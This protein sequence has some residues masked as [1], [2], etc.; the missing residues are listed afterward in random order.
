M[1]QPPPQ[2]ILP[3]AMQLLAPIQSVSH[4]YDGSESGRGGSSLGATSNAGADDSAD[5]H[6]VDLSIRIGTTGN[7]VGSLGHLCDGTDADGIDCKGEDKGETALDAGEGGELV[8]ASYNICVC[9]SS[10][11][12]VA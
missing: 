8:A 9:W 11:A 7:P 4:E 12:F 5:L 3:P 1:P 2:Y 10:W 6:G